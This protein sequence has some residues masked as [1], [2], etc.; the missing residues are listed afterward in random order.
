M[1]GP[2]DVRDLFAQ[3]EVGEPELAE[4]A[5]APRTSIARPIHISGYDREVR[6]FYATPD[7]VTEALLR[8][9]QFRGRVWE[10]CCGAGAITTVMQRHGYDV[11]S[12]D[13]ADHGFGAPGVDF[14]SCQTVP[15]GCRGIVTNP[16]YGDTKSL[17]GQEKSSM[18]MLHFVDH[19]LR[20]TESVQ[21]QLALLVRFQWVAGKRAAALMSVG[22]FAAVIALTRR[23]QWF[24]KGADTNIS[25]HHHAWV[26]FDHA[27][28]VG[29][30]PALLF[31]DQR[32]RSAYLTEK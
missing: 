24:N 23:I 11:T 31:A 5:Q 4:R 21:G 29:Q 32:V 20:L 9:V 3:S 6:D 7:W 2:R 17:K 18:A 25:Q 8:H 13:I 28:P 16:P 22:P 27:H 26:V 30:P 15:E 1:E 19:A 12:T 14:L 10:P